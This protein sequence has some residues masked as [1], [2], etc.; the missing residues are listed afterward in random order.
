[1][2]KKI[3][4]LDGHPSE[5][6]YVACLADE[7]ALNAEKGGFEVKTLNVRD[8]DFDPNL[9]WGYAR[10]QEL[11]PDLK[12]SQELVL[13][14]DHLVLFTP[15]WWFSIPALLKGFFDRAFLPGFA[16]KIDKSVGRKV[17]K[18]LSGR[19][20]TIFYTFGGHKVDLN[21]KFTDPVRTLLKNGILNFVGFKNIKTHCLYKTLGIENIKSREKFI[22]DVIKIGKQGG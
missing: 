13:W 1:M 9:K 10:K 14:C 21:E 8:L 19:T 18:L 22:N 11:E 4:V 3:L 6:S 2:T 17:I 7:Y 16:F 15:V 5:F 20:A 12:M